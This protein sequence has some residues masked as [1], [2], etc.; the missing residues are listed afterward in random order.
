MIGKKEED[1]VETPQSVCCHFTCPSVEGPATSAREE[2]RVL[3]LA[4][5]DF[6]DAGG[7]R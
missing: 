4:V 7:L 3:S 2:L 5:S 1:G 6:S